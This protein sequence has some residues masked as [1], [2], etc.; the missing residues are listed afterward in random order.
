MGI[1]VAVFLT[2]YLFLCLARFSFD[3]ST[4]RTI[5]RFFYFLVPLTLATILII[6][7][8]FEHNNKNE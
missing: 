5:D 2:A 4:M 7:F 3:I 1:I 8:N 6:G